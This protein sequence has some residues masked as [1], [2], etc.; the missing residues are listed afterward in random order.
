[1]SLSNNF[2]Q[3]CENQYHFMYFYVPFIQYSTLFFIVI[4]KHLLIILIF[5]IFFFC[6]YD[7]MCTSKTVT[8]KW[9]SVLIIKV[10]LS[11]LLQILFIAKYLQSHILMIAVGIIILGLCFFYKFTYYYI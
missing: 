11:S 1:M 9:R 10:N 7:L 2:I 3:N 5:H 6:F 4:F 8:S